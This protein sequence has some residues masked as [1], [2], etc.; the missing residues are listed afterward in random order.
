MGDGETSSRSLGDTGRYLREPGKEREWQKKPRSSGQGEGHEP[1]ELA[2][3]A[4]TERMQG[5]V[6]K[7]LAEAAERPP[8]MRTSGQRPAVTTLGNGSQKLQ[9]TRSQCREE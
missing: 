5:R 4:R 3:G 2:M 8:G 9:E 6:V 7:T 1:G